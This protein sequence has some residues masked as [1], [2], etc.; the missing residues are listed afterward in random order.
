MA[1]VKPRQ[2]HCSYTVSSHPIVH[3]VL[4]CTLATAVAQQV[5]VSLRLLRIARGRQL[6]GLSC[7]MHSLLVDCRVDEQPLAFPTQFSQQ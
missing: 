7:L 4:E 3:H 6:H 1:E 5:H 2:L